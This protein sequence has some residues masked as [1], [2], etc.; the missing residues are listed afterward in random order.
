MRAVADHLPPK[1]G[2]RTLK[3]YRCKQ[4]STG[5][6][7]F[8]FYCNNP[9]LVHFSYERYLENV[10]RNAFDFKGTPLRLEFR[11]KGKSHLI[12]ENREGKRLRR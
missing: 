5:P 1:H 7:S 2:S 6:P 10:I 11:G 4:E 3:I 9:T 12:G 8:I